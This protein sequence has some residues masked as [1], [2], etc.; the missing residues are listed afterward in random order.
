MDQAAP[1][2]GESSVKSALFVALFGTLTALLAT[3]CIGPAS[4]NGAHRDHLTAR[5]SFELACP[6]ES[7]QHTVLERTSTDVVTR[8]GVHG[9]GQ[10]EIYD[11][12]PSG[13]WVASRR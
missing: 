6:P 5:A 3:G 13:Q 10:D 4:Y 8:Y 2:P 12:G 9:C 7:L 1:A 11:L